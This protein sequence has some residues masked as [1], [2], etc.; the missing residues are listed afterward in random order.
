MSPASA[1]ADVPAIIS[2]AELGAGFGVWRNEVRDGRP[3]KVPY[4]ISGA[5]AKANDPTLQ[6]PTSF[7]VGSMLCWLPSEGCPSV[8][9]PLKSLHFE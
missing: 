1:L 2:M 9:S 3:T 8:L 4:Q 6:L 5:R 7:P